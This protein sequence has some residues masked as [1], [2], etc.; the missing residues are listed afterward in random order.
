MNR[1]WPHVVSTSVGVAGG[2]F[3]ARREPFCVFVCWGVEDFVCCWPL[4]SLLDEILSPWVGCW[5][6][7]LVLICGLGHGS[8]LGGVLSSG[9][10]RSWD[11]N[12]A[13]ALI[14]YRFVLGEDGGGGGSFRPEAG[15][16]TFM[17]RRE[18]AVGSPR[19]GPRQA[20]QGQA[21]EKLEEEGRLL[22]CPATPE[23]WCC[24]RSRHP[25]ASGYGLRGDAATNHERRLRPGGCRPL[26]PAQRETWR[27]PERHVWMG[28][29]VSRN[30]CGTD[31]HWE[32]KGSGGGTPVTVLE[33]EPQRR[34]LTIAGEEALPTQL[35]SRLLPRRQEQQPPP[36]LAQWDYAQYRTELGGPGFS[37]FATK[38]TSAY[39]RI[40]PHK[41]RDY[42]IIFGRAFI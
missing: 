21:E 19:V 12:L 37:F 15:P 16:S 30:E 32:G 13:E 38:R 14:V 35:R 17:W 27:L 11:E 33:R 42:W 31:P 40:Q 3:L 25:A 1:L 7:Y 10:V 2:A 9:V 5:G 23:C 29:I 20:I 24:P 26:C 36:S 22:T 8:L 4:R 34:H 39:D 28:G 41:T 18:E 6:F